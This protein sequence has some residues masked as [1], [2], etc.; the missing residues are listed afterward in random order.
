MRER[1]G[2]PLVVLIA[3][4][5]DCSYTLAKLNDRG[6]MNAVLHGRDESTATMLREIAQDSL[7][8]EK[9]VLLG[10]SSSAAAS[11]GGMSGVA[12]GASGSN[13]AAATTA[14]STLASQQQ[15][16]QCHASQLQNQSVPLP[17][18]N[19]WLQQRGTEPMQPEP[20]STAGA[21]SSNRRAERCVF[22]RQLPKGIQAREVHRFLTSTYGIGVRQVSL[23]T[24]KKDATGRTRFAHVQCS[25]KDADHLIALSKQN[26]LIY[27][28]E[29]VSAIDDAKPMS[30]GKLRKLPSSLL[31]R[32][33][34]STIDDGNAGG[35]SDE[36][37][38]K[39]GSSMGPVDDNIVALC[40][41]LSTKQ[42]SWGFHKSV[43]ED[44]CWVKTLCSMR[45]NR[46]TTKMSRT[47]S[48]QSTTER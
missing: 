14:A 18:S 40:V 32:D 8:F 24:L 45:S 39:S 47:S 12:S 48:R 9:D 16:Q 4:D 44:V 19:D 17:A 46:A 25:A 30:A 38:L 29:C 6:V 7:S 11:G 1:G 22:L 15:Q 26:G 28:D 23:E 43:A 33:P 10:S 3:S 42:K 5:G 36:A 31:Y 13:A 37:S 27:K 41:C 20:T 21:T 35:F 2:Q 34:R